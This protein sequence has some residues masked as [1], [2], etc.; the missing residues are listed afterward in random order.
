MKEFTTYKGTVYPWHCDQMGHMNVMWYVG[1]FDE[2]VWHF[3]NDIGLK[4]SAMRGEDMGIVAAEQKLKYFK[5][6]L[7]GDIVSVKSSIVSVSDKTMTIKHDMYLT[8]SNEIAASSELICI[9]F[10]K[11]ARRAKSL[12]D[13]VKQVLKE[14]LE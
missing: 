1:K 11:K 9:Y 2:A 12:P 14:L 7:A 13:D 8:E 5:E 4:A 10:D 3:F 6:C